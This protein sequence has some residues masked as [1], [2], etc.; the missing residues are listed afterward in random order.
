M[1]G[2]YKRFFIV[3]FLLCF[4]FTSAQ[5]SA[6]G[7]IISLVFK[8]ITIPLTFLANRSSALLHAGLKQS[9]KIGKT[10]MSLISVQAGPVKIRPFDF[11]KI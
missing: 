6:S 8:P 11:K 10:T 2:K 1:V 3:F 9:T 4:S 7:K 5:A